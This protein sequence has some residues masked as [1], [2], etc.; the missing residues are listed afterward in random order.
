MTNGAAALFMRTAY[1]NPAI[2]FGDTPLDRWVTAVSPRWPVR[3]GVAFEN[4]AGSG[5]NANRRPDAPDPAWAARGGATRWL[6]RPRPRCRQNGPAR[7]DPVS[8]TH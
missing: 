5:R 4:L 6:P 7:S 8:Y 2:Y 1:Q 3:A